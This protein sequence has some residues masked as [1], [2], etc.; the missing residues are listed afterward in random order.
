[1]ET[2]ITLP[3]QKINLKTENMRIFTYLMIAFITLIVAL[4]VNAQTIVSDGF[5]SWTD[6]NHPSL[7]FGSKTSIAASNVTQYTTSVHG[8]TYAVQ[9]TS[10]S[11]SH[12]RFTSQPVSVTA[13][14]VYTI[15]FWVRGHGNIRT[16]IWD[17]AYGTYNAYINV[18]SATWAQQSQTVTAA[19][20]STVAEF[21]FSVQS[22]VA[23]IDHLQID[24]VSI[25]GPG[26]VSAVINITAP[27]YNQVIYSPDVNVNFVVSNFVVANGTGDG[28]VKHTVDGGAAAYTYD[29]NPIAITG[30]AAGQHT[31]VLELVDNSNAS[32]SPVAV[33][34]VKIT[35][36]LT[37]PVVKTIY[38]LQYTTAVPA[39]SPY[40]GQLV[41]TTGVVTGICSSGFFIQ[42]GTGQYNGIFVFTSS[43]TVTRGDNVTVTG[44]VDEYY[45]YTE[46]KSLASVTINS[47]GNAEPAVS[48]VTSAG[49]KSEP[50]ESVLVQILNAK[51]TNINSGY[52]MWT[53]KDGLNAGDTCKIHNL[54]YTMTPTLNIIYAI[55]GPVYYS[56][57]EFR[58]EPRSAADVTVGINEVYTLEANVYPNPATD[59]V[60]ISAVEP[61]ALVTIT[62]LQ[63]RMVIRQLSNGIN[64]TK[65]NVSALANGMYEIVAYG[66]EG[67]VFRSKFLK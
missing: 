9:L 11:T 13:G 47:S 58:V 18:N 35:T 40:M 19:S 23:D 59:F 1:M 63:G 53:V 24:D 55:T 27:A 25:T 10:T 67:N 20:T 2:I 22:T 45:E 50:Y 4:N 43:F 21:I 41:T 28:H 26:G 17:G 39:N 66:K 36:N 65:I 5:E 12:A 6:P 57:N 29:T 62:D 16:N 38:E 49:V 32:L 30:L 60:N 51:C 3:L 48:V 7:W 8:G 56:F 44:L 54:L 37:T 15:S 46:I 31:I 14:T 64:E 42:D 61:I 33:D 34:T 52:G